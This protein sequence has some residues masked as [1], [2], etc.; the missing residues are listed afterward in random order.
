MTALPPPSRPDGPPAVSWQRAAVWVVV[1]G[2]GVCLIV[3]GVVGMIAKG[4]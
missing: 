1:A 2:I 3:T 4:G